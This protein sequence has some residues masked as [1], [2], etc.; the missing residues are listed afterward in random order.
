MPRIIQKPT[1]GRIVLV[2]LQNP[3][4]PKG[5][6]SRPA[7]VI[8]AFGGGD[9]INAKVQLDCNDASVPGR[10]EAFTLDVTSIPFDGDGVLLDANNNHVISWRWPP[11]CD[12][13]IEV[14]GEDPEPTDAAAAV[15]TAAVI[16]AKDAEIEALKAELA[17]RAALDP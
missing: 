5:V 8:Q 4:D 7:T 15:D 13:K 6:I 3:S 12:D 2:S 10:T 1:A 17:A 9:L 11:R 14:A 16:A